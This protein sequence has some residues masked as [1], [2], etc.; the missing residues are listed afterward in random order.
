[1]AALA[2]TTTEQARW[3]LGRARPRARHTTILRHTG[4]LWQKLA[5]RADPAQYCPHALPDIAEE[6][7]NEGWA[8]INRDPQPARKLPAPDAGAACAVAANG[9]HAHNPPSLRRRRSSSSTNCCRSAI[10]SQALKQEG[11][12]RDQ[13]IGVYRAIAARLEAHTAASWGS[14]VLRFLTGQ[15]F[16]LR[17]IDR[18]LYGDLSCVWLAVLY[19]AVRRALGG[20]CGAWWRGVCALV[21]HTSSKPG[22]ATG[23]LPLQIA[24]LWVALLISFLLHESA[25]A[26][27]VK[28]FGRTL[29]G[30]GMMLYFGAPAF[31]CRYQRHLALAAPR[32]ACWFRRLARCPIY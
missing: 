20:R 8:A 15:R 7:V 21:H 29:R 19:A 12:L 13:P 26:L 2:R 27:A 32:P 18:P 11:F 16:S 6:Q 25:H 1:M 3:Y 31:L 5:E 28:H 30:G 9:R 14:R 23:G 4:A 22:D 10:W 24:S 17:N